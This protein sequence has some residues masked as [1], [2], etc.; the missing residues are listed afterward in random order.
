MNTKIC[1]DCGNKKPL[2]KFN[3]SLTRADKLQPRCKKCES[4][5]YKNYYRDKKLKKAQAD[6]R[7]GQF[8]Y[9]I[10]KDS[11]T[12]L[13]EFKAHIKHNENIELDLSGYSKEELNKVIQDILE[14]ETDRAEQ[15][16][17]IEKEIEAENIW[18]KHCRCKNFGN[19]RGFSEPE[20][21]KLEAILK[22]QG[23]QD[24]HN[25]WIKTNG[26]VNEL[27]NFKPSIWD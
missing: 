3:R 24:P 11:Q 27:G 17:I 1:S 25:I 20:R 15:R 21:V 7:P 23:I 22:R 8:N 2:T 6:S 12:L 14:S 18:E 26:R 5:R 16:K 13:K 9:V 19:E 4:L 10:N